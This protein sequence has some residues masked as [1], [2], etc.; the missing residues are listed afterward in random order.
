MTQQDQRLMGLKL[1]GENES[2]FSH[3]LKSETKGVN[4]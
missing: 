4:L 2:A 3:G 1:F